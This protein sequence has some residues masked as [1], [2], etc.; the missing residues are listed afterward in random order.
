[1]C[2]TN[3]WHSWVDAKRPCLLAYPNAY[4]PGLILDSATVL[5]A[6]LAAQKEGGVGAPTAIKVFTSQAANLAQ[7]ATA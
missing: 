5:Q 4:Q 3:A 2:L 1:M 6:W 7:P